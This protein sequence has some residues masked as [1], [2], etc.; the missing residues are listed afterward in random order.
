MI[1]GSSS[2]ES[3]EEPLKLQTKQKKLSSSLKLE[4]PPSSDDEV[5]A[6]V[7]TPPRETKTKEVKTSG[8]RFFQIITYLK[9]KGEIDNFINKFLTPKQE[10]QSPFSPPRYF[11]FIV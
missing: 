2:Y 6:P 9:A 3:E 1:K 11:F 10:P 8:T 7:D 4:F 5:N